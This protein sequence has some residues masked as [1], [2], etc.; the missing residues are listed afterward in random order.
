M[1]PPSFSDC[2]IVEVRM[3]AFHPQRTFAPRL[4]EEYTKKLKEAVGRVAAYFHIE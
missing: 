4:A 2:A 1:P 3:S